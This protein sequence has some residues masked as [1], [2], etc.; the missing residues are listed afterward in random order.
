[1]AT[2]NIS[3]PD[4]MKQWVEQQ[5]RSGHYSN[6]SDY[7]RDLIRRDYERA[8][9]VA[10]LQALVT[11]GIQSGAGERSMDELKAA[12]KALASGA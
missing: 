3:L 7:V 6:S 12:A 2:M 8:V 1:M 9:K 11:E 4:A 5:G 10:R